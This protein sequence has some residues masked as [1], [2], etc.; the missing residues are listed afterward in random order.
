MSEQSV[1]VQS[2]HFHSWLL[3]KGVHRLGEWKDDEFPTS[4][5]SFS[6][7][8]EDWRREVD[9]DSTPGVHIN[10]RGGTVF[11]YVYRGHGLIQRMI[12][13]QTY[14]T[15]VKQGQF[16]CVNEPCVLAQVI[17]GV[18]SGILIKRYGYNGMF[19]V[20]GPLEDKG[21]LKYI[22][23]CTDS[24]LV[25][26][27]LKGDACLNAL[28]FPPGINQTQ[29]THPSMR[30]GMV[31]SGQGYCMVPEGDVYLRPGVLFQI[32]KDGLHSFRTAEEM[33]MV[34]LA[35]HPDSDFGPEHE[36]H[37]MINRTIVDG[38]SA[39]ELSHIQTK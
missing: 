18:F 32:P 12:K 36:Q 31:L 17:P 8:M 6:F 16:F 3:E 5:D 19:Q 7:D 21:R 4:F 34:V 27:V 30:V 25:P 1:A 35:Y 37:P 10:A 9:N 13:G 28:F 11:G 20:G 39:S 23:G 38:V 22:D 14:N 26:P 29:H 33:G 15:E 2:Q 24:L